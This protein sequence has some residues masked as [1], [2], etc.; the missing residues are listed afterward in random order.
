MDLLRSLERRLVAAEKACLAA[1]LL[2]M[3]ALS[4]LQVLLRGGFS[5]GI[6]WAD[7]LLRHLVLWVGFLGAA[8]AAADDKQ[9]AL[10]AAGRLLR[11]RAKAAAHV[12]CALFAAATTAWLA[13]AGRDFLADERAAGGTL[14]TVGQT[15]VPA[16]PF[17]LVLP[18]GFAL[19]TL[20]Y[21]LKAAL[22]APGLRR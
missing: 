1:L 20:H 8:A 17:E 19:L 13:A 5:K 22:A 12:L 2:V 9:F 3:V 6:L 10:D 4:F 11:G 16:W 14:F 18:W 7:T 21:L 15:Q